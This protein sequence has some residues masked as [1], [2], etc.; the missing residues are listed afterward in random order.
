MTLTGAST[1][2]GSTTVNAGTLQF[3]KEVSLYNDVTS[4]WT[5]TNIIVASGATAAFNVGGT[6]EF[7]SADIDILKALGTASGGFQS[8]SFLAL[9]TTNAS[10]GTFTYS[11]NIANPNSGANVLG[12]TKLGTGALVLSGTNTYTGGTSLVPDPFGSEATAW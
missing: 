3:G 12:L 7:T 6:G 8:G 1:F 5:A 4:N 9:D 10:G 11:S 2:S